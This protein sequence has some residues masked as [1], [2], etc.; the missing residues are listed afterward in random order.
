MQK[1]K[2]RKTTR[3]KKLPSTVLDSNTHKRSQSD[4][5]FGYVAF[6]TAASISTQSCMCKPPSLLSVV[7][8]NLIQVL[9]AVISQH[10]VDGMFIGESFIK[11]GIIQF[12]CSIPS[13]IFGRGELS[14]PIA[15]CSSGNEDSLHCN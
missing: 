2:T 10:A 11:S 14:L 5:K 3:I 6:R 13:N 7:S 12:L 8:D 15:C 1:A 9:Y 4:C